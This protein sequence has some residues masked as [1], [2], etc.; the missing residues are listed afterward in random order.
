MKGSEKTRESSMNLKT[1]NYCACDQRPHV[2]I[3]II[4]VLGFV[5]M[6]I[7][8]GGFSALNFVCPHLEYLRHTD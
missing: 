2:N 5:W 4:I 6:E 8:T 3:I 1:D 7:S